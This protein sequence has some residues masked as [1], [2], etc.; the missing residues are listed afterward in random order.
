MLSP[1]TQSLHD[2][3]EQGQLVKH[4]DFWFSDGSV[5]LRAQSTL[6]R[7][8]TSLLCRKSAFFRDL[9]S[10]PQPTAPDRE[11]RRLDGCLVLDLHDPPEDVANLIKVVYDG[12]YVLDLCPFPFF[13][14]RV[15]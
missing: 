3:L 15:P 11:E 14:F 2:Q 13:R 8:H 9:F 1:S 5:I 7:V 4:P 12:P 10:L 6:F